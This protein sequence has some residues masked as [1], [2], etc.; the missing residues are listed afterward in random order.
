VIFALSINSVLDILI[1]SY[2]FWAPTVLVPLAAALLGLGVSRRR[3]LA[4]AAGGVIGVLAWKYLLAS[5]FGID[6][7]VVG[8]LI[9]LTCFFAV[10]RQS[11]VRRPVVEEVLK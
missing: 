3:F 10:D 9:N 4:G 1:Y 7:L 8:T 2:N 6:G 11:A 5:P